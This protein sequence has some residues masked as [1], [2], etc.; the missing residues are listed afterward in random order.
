M[1][2]YG[3]VR[4]KAIWSMLDQCAPGHKRKKRIHKWLISWKGKSYPSLPT[5]EHGKRTDPQIELGHIKKMIRF[6]GIDLDCAKS[7]IPQLQ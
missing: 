3:Q 2:G 6:L 4:L 5:G 1:A 7:E